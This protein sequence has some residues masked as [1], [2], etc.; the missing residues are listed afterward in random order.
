MYFCLQ[1]DINLTVIHIPLTYS[2]NLFLF[3]QPILDGLL[4]Q[5]G[6]FQGVHKTGD[7]CAQK[8]ILP[9]FFSPSG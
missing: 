1:T 7:R 6:P 5:L 8:V 4:V 2:D 9:F 3:Y